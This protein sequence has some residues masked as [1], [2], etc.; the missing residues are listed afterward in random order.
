[1]SIVLFGTVRRLVP[2]NLKISAISIFISVAGGLYAFKARFK[3]QLRAHSHKMSSHHV[4]IEPARWYDLQV[5]E[6][7]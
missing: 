4:A 3:E 2:S 7:S 6:T 1:M 5:G